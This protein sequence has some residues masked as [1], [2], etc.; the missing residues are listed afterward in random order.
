MMSS[1]RGVSNLEPLGPEPSNLGPAR[2]PFLAARVCSGT[3]TLSASTSR[4]G[5]ISRRP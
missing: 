3:L 4:G 2:A 1:G 5:G